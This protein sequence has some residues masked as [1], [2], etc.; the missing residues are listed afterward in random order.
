M[1]TLLG[2]I[3]RI[4]GLV[5]NGLGEARVGVDALADLSS[6]NPKK[7]GIIGLVL[8]WM[9]VDPEVLVTLSA[10]LSKVSGWLMLL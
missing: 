3:P 6:K 5:S 7:S 10:I 8:G 4:L 1:D 2:F 9:G